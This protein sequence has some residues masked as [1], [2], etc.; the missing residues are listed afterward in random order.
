MLMGGLPKANLPSLV[1]H[2]LMIHPVPGTFGLVVTS[3][4][5]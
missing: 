3:G 5:R 4:A 1:H 2:W